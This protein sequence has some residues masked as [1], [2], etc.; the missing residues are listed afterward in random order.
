MH[1]L[2]PLGGLVKNKFCRNEVSFA[3][4]PGLR[5]FL[6]YSFPRAVDDPEERAPIQQ[7]RIVSSLFCCLGHLAKKLMINSVILRHQT[8]KYIYSEVVAAFLT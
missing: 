1:P 7:W 2:Y 8:E 4:L 3:L 5:L 6:V